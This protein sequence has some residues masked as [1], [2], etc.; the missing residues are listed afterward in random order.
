MSTT[1]SEADPADCQTVLL[2]GVFGSGKSSVAAEMA[3]EFERRSMPYAAVDLDWLRWFDVGSDDPEAGYRVMIANLEAVTA[4][5]LAAGVRFLVLALSVEHPHRLDA[6][7]SAV[8]QPL[9]VVRLVVDIETIE[10]RCA[11]DPTSGRA[12]DIEW[13]RRWYEDDTGA[14]L[15]DFAVTNDRPLPLVAAEVIDRLGW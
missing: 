15:E 10:R 3:T 13:A 2:T 6:I 5:Y 9:R 8:P 4:N 14:G 1:R 7:R 11:D 12:I